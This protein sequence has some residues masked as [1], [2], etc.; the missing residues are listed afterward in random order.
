MSSRPN[1]IAKAAIVVGHRQEE[2]SGCC[3]DAG[4]HE[5]NGG[6]DRDDDHP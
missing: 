4:R 3:P 6:R 5:D 1:R 2:R